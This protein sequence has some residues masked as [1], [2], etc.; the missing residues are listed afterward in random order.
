MEFCGAVRSDPAKPTTY[1]GYMSILGGFLLDNAFQQVTG[2]VPTVAPKVKGAETAIESVSMRFTEGTSDKEYN[3]RLLHDGTDYLVK[4]WY[5]R[6][7]KKLTELIKVQT[8]HRVTAMNQF[9][10]LKHDKL[11]KGYRVV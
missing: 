8:P 3:M 2:K 10:R 6:H 4:V 11:R 9:S 7:G 5:G 1:K